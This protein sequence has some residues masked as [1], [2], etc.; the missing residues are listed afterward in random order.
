MHA[1]PA[2]S[3]LQD[4]ALILGTAAVATV[5]FQ[6]FRL[7]VIVG[8]LA[9]GM[10]VRPLIQN[11]DTIR[12]L[13][14]LGVVLLL[15]SIGLEFRFRRLAQLGPRVGLAMVVEVGLML[16]LGYGAARLL[17]L[18]GISSLI[19]AG[20]VAISSTMVSS[21]TMTEIK[22]DRTLREVVLGVLVM[23]DLAAIL[24]I[25]DLDTWHGITMLGGFQMG[26]WAYVLTFVWIVW[27]VNNTSSAVIGLP[28]CHLRLG[29]SLIV[30]FF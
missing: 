22:A 26:N 18:T 29:L 3:F 11:P 7:P 1:E 8:Y 9:A 21:S 27:M 12:T 10:L 19:A 14:E 24:L 15:F 17:G 23:E 6:R 5:L 30:Y 20:L 28:S 16:L 13:A 2:F 4:L 25:A